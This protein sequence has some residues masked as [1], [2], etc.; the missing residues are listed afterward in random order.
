MK[1]LPKIF[2]TILPALYLGNAMGAAAAMSSTKDNLYNSLTPITPNLDRTKVLSTNTPTSSTNTLRVTSSN[3]KDRME[4]NALKDFCEPF[5]FNGTQNYG[6]FYDDCT[7]PTPNITII[8]YEKKNIRNPATIKKH[9]KNYCFSNKENTVTID[10]VKERDC[11]QAE[12]DALNAK[13]CKTNDG[14]K[15][16]YDITCKNTNDIVDGDTDKC[17]SFNKQQVFTF[18][19]ENSTQNDNNQINLHIEGLGHDYNECRSSTNTITSPSTNITVKCTKRIYF[20][21]TAEP[22][23]SIESIGGESGNS[24]DV[25]E[26]TQ[27]TIVIK[28]KSSN[29]ENAEDQVS[30][31]ANNDEDA[32][33]A[34]VVVDPNTPDPNAP[35]WSEEEINAARDAAESARETENSDV[36]KM[37]G[38]T[39]MGATGIGGMM[40]MQGLAEKAAD[41]EATRAMQAYIATFNCEVGNNRV[42]GGV[43]AEVPGGNELINLY[44]EYVNLAN[45]VKEMKSELGLRPGIESEPILDSAT[46]GLYDDVSV[47]GTS[48]A[49]ASLAR[50]LMDP[51][52]KDAAAWAEQT[53]KTSKNIKTGAITAGTGA[54]VSLIGDL[55]NKAVEKKKAEKSE[56]EKKKKDKDEAE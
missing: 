9:Y 21:I 15:H 45:N 14:G 29:D 53:E 47:A 37:L 28:L 4:E 8:C 34:T 22:V 36:N 38:A 33:V 12:A 32:K 6:N 30:D 43:T 24:L 18:Q 55:T 26:E 35:R 31:D 17:V 10:K 1:I 19:I 23:D 50:A 41:D 52:G 49:Y 13:S 51:Y 54:G 56:K 3:Q 5:D 39:G 40:L 46:S 42:P 11:T 25:T 16:F 7:S 44:G 2:L 20:Q 48:G 27:T